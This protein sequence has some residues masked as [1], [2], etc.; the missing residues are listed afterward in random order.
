MIA[1]NEHITNLKWTL[2]GIKSDLIID[3]I[4]IDYRRLIIISNRVASLSDISI[5]NN[6]IKNYNNIDAN[7]L[8]DV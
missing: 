4:C 1:S 3:F 5:I 2:K 7:N 8:Q 6:Y